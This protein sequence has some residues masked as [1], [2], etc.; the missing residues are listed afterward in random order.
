MKS[1]RKAEVRE[2]IVTEECIGKGIPEDP[3][4]V[5]TV[6]RDK[7]GDFV[8]EYDPSQLEG[9]YLSECIMLLREIEN[10]NQID[11]IRR[12][13]RVFLSKI[14]KLEW[15]ER[16]LQEYLRRKRVDGQLVVG[17]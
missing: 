14:E 13:V 5:L 9:L 4:R 15:I 17:D 10:C 11:E 3:M 6:V 16:V 7:N 2:L 8:A 12:M 1:I